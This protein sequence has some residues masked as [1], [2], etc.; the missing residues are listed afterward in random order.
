MELP[1]WMQTFL[2]AYFVTSLPGFGIMVWHAWRTGE[3]L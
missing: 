1:I 3:L 2:L